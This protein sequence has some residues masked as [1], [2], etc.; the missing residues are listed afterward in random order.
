MTNKASIVCYLVTGV[1]QEKKSRLGLEIYGDGE[2]PP[3][4]RERCTEIVI[5]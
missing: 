5:I 4:D 3:E 2:E 1:M